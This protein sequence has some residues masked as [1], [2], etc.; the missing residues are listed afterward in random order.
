MDSALERSSPLGA[1]ADPV[2]VL[3]RK[4]DHLGAGVGV[5]ELYLELQGLVFACESADL[6]APAA[7]RPDGLGSLV[8]V[9]TDLGA[10]GPVDA[11]GLGGGDGEVDQAAAAL[12][13]L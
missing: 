9:D 1:D 4:L 5:Q 12:R 13:P 3:A 2:G 11:C 8:N 6:H 7:A 10:A